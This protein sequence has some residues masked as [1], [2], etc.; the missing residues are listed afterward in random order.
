MNKVV[1]LV[2]LR[3]LRSLR[4]K[5]LIMGVGRFNRRERRER[6]EK[7]PSV[8]SVFLCPLSRPVPARTRGQGRCRRYDR[9]CPP[10]E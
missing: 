8:V 3:S 5:M 1:S 2:S 10:N 4:L 9:F 7:G 6:R